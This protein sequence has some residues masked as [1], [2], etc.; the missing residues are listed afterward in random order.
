MNGIG[1]VLALV[2]ISAIVFAIF[3][4]IKRKKDLV[5]YTGYAE[6]KVIDVEEKTIK[7]I[8]RHSEKRYYPTIEF[9]IG[10][11]DTVY[12]ETIVS[13]YNPITPTKRY[14][15]NQIVYVRYNPKFYKD[16]YLAEDIKEANNS[17][18]FLIAGFFIYI[19]INLMFAKS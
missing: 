16:F 5:D 14:V 11:E 17:V 15:V 2:G 8:S 19:A 7:S 3:Q 1:I 6:G 12:P 10:D 13:Q 18:L 4:N 9:T